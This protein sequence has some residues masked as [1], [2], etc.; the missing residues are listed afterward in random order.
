MV[1]KTYLLIMAL[2][3]LTAAVLAK[4]VTNPILK[5]MYIKQATPDITEEEMR[6]LENKLSDF[7][8][9]NNL[10]PDASIWDVARVLN[11]IDR[12]SVDNI[13]S[14]ARIFESENGGDF[15][16]VHNKRVPSNEQLFDFAHE[17]G[18]KINDDPMPADRPHGYNK[19]KLDQLADYTGAALLMPRE[20]VY[21][22]LVDNQYDSASPHK[23]VALIKK[24]SKTYKVSETLTVRRVNEVRL[25]M[26]MISK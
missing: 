11:V 15:T 26:N 13:S 21:N 20:Q 24:L 1:L 22:F 12:G 3:L 4:Y 5:K 19:P 6:T 7:L 14:R 9:E 18:H 10:S 25:L 16:V 17:L 23:R 8:K 2:S